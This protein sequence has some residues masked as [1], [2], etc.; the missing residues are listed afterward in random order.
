MSAFTA[1]AIFISCLGLLGLITYTVAQRTRE[2]G[3]RKVI[4]AGTA[5]IVMLFGRQYFKLVLIAN[6]IAWPVA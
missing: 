6:F 2:I 4:G 3:I 5:D 1:I